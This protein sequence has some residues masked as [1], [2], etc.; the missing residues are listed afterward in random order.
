ARDP[1][2]ENAARARFG[3]LFHHGRRTSRQG[4]HFRGKRRAAERTFGARRRRSTRVALQ[5]R[6]RRTRRTGCDGLGVQSPGYKLT[7][8]RNMKTKAPGK[9]VLSGAYAVLEGAPCIVT[10]V[11][12]YVYADS[13]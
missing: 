12:R 10:A 5:R 7:C 2:S 13:S 4:A 3:R 9:V 6:P 8:D 11:D 1:R